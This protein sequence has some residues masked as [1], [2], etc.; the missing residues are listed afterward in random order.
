MIRPAL[1]APLFLAA[2]AAAPVQEGPVPAIEV[3][4]GLDEAVRIQGLRLIPLEVVEDSRCPVDVQCVW[5]GRLRVR[6]AIQ[7]PAFSQTEILELGQG[8]AL[9]DARR[10]ALTEALPAPRQGGAPDAAAYRLT[11][12]VGPGD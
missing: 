6:V 7:A 5:A 2:C 12:T 4:A 10:L 9:E 8:I 11:F 3:T 1:L